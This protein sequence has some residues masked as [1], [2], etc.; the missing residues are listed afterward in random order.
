MGSNVM[1]LADSLHH[2]DMR[3]ISTNFGWSNTS[4]ILDLIMK[5]LHRHR[6]ARRHKNYWREG[7]DFF[8]ISCPD[9]YRKKNLSGRKSQPS[10]PPVHKPCNPSKPS[11]VFFFLIN[12]TQRST[13]YVDV[14]EIII[15]VCSDI[16]GCI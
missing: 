11:I 4:Y 3:N 1:V 7:G 12:F 15:K 14:H 6:Y 2:D 10:P 16:N 5:S 13:P 9:F 8:F